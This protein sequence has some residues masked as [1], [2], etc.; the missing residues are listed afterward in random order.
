MDIK[1]FF[2]DAKTIIIIILILLLV[3]LVIYSVHVH[4]EN[5]IYKNNIEALTDSLSSVELKNQT[6]L[7]QK[8]MLI[9]EKEDIE[10]MLGISESK[11]KE[12]ENKLKANA[13]YIADLESN[14]KIDTIIMHDSVYVNNDTVY[15]YFDKTDKWYDI[16][17]N[18]VYYNQNAT[19]IIDSLSVN[20]PLT[21]GITDD[22]RIFANSENPYISISSINAAAIDKNLNSKPKRWGFGPFIGIGVGYGFGTNFNGGNVGGFGGLVTGITVGVSIHY[23]LLQW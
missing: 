19:T 22:N 23:S 14:V 15:I 7:Y 8:K 18:S 4:D 6:L 16:S 2:S 13:I 20:V 3:C 1:K 11:L 12:M 5:N 21:L 10:K 9:L 17:G